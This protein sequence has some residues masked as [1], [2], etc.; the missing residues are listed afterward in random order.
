MVRSGEPLPCKRLQAGDLHSRRLTDG[1][2]AVMGG[3]GCILKKPCLQFTP[4]LLSFWFCCLHFISASK[5]WERFFL[6][7]SI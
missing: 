6:A 7:L 2:Q 5:L 1:L 3:W 4:N